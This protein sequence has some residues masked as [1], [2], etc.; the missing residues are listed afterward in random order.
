MTDVMALKTARTLLF[1][2]GNRPT[3]IEKARR[4]GADLVIVDFEDSLA[5]D[6]KVLARA[7]CAAQ[8]NAAQPVVIR[9][10]AAGTPWFEDDL[11]FCAHPGVSAIILPRAV[12]GIALDTAANV[13][14]V[15]AM[16]ETGLGALGMQAT[17]ATPGVERLTIGLIDLALDLGVTAR[18]ALDT[19]LLDLVIAS[20]AVG[21]APP[22]A[23][24]TQ[25]FRDEAA[26]TRE[27]AR[28]YALGFTAKLCIHPAQI[29]PTFAG[30]RPTEE[31]LAMARR[32]ISAAAGSGGSAS[33]IEGSMIDRP[34]F[35]RARQVLALA[36]EVGR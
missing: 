11:E 12:P 29:A 20:R 4:S 25:D 15:V 8:L 9:I 23:P 31:E 19:V 13:R 6:E 3:N 30:L 33:S 1:V 26:V 17:A 16:I 32:I 24:V 36:G 18:E 22:I 28:Y 5:Q 35:D 27:T 10:N 21:I 2:P 7:G 34:V 14:P